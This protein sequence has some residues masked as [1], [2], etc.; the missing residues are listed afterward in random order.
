M[1]SYDNDLILLLLDDDLFI[2]E[3]DNDVDRI[4][5]KSPENSGR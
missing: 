2:I 4:Q 3:D 5:S 1:D